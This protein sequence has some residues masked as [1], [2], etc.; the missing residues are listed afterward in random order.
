MEWKLWLHFTSHSNPIRYRGYY[1][2]SET[3]L[4]YLLS[5]YYD[6]EVGRFI[7][8]DDAGIV[9]T[10]PTS[11]YDKNL[12]AY[13][14]NNPVNRSDNNG[15]FW[16]VVIGAVIGAIFE[17][18][19]QVIAN[20]GI[21]D[22]NL[23]KIA[24]AAVVGGVT[25]LTG[26]TLGAIISG[27]GNG[28]MEIMSGIEDLVKIGT[29]MIVGVGASLIGTEVGT[30]CKKIGGKI[31]VNSLA[32]KNPGF[33]KKTVLSKINVKGCY[34]N[35]VKNL[36][37]AVENYKNLPSLLIGKSIPQTFNSLAVGLS[38]YGTMGAIYGFK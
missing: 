23:G 1:Y 4:Y 29:S 18:G 10:D 35:K 20:E 31:A 27:I 19:S 34:R 13:C 21:K 26:V 38:G 15:Y 6:S 2:D 3:N 30:L 24:V 36:S 16:H 32:K 11:F 37:W 9:M 33:I 12:Y 17:F 5:R 28:V 8:S 14:D 25:A 22:I 7:S